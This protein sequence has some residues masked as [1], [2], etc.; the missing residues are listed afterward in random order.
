MVVA[1]FRERWLGGALPRGLIEKELRRRGTPLPIRT[2]DRALARAVSQRDLARITSRD[3]GTLYALRSYAD[4]NPVLMESLR[5]APLRSLQWKDE[6]LQARAMRR[7]LDSG[8]REGGHD[9][10]PGHKCITCGYRPCLFLTLQNPTKKD[11]LAVLR[12][13]ERIGAVHRKSN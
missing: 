9:Y 12:K 8:A 7:Y 10:R 5:N 1:L 2:M 13:I 4:S 3:G 11:F 6:R